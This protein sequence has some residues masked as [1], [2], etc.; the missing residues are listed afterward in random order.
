MKEPGVD[1]NETTQNYR[2]TNVKGMHV[3]FC[4]K[5]CSYR[6]ASSVYFS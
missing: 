1:N 5:W 2:V 4:N 6:P 3:K